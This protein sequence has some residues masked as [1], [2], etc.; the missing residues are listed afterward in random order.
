MKLLRVLMP[1]SLVVMV[2]A[3][4]L[5]GVGGDGQLDA[6]CGRSS[7]ACEVEICCGALTDGAPT[8]EPKRHRPEPQG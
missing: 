5:L 3:V 7:L 1:T 8:R 2:V 4:V 6:D